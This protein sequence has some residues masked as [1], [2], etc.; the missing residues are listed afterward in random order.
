MSFELSLLSKYRTPLMGIAMLCV[1]FFHLPINDSEIPFILR[2]I[3]RI[4]FG[5]VDFFFFLSGL[6]IYFSMEKR[7]LKD[8]YQKRL[9]RILPYYIPVVA[10]FSLFFEYHN[11]LISIKDALLKIF[12]LDFWIQGNGL[13]W[14]IPVAI[15]FYI[16]TPFIMKCLCLNN[17]KYSVLAISVLLSVDLV[18]NYLFHYS[19][20]MYILVR[21]SDYILGIQIGYFITK[22]KRINIAWLV[23]SF[24]IGGLT[25][26]LNYLYSYQGGFIA[27][28]FR[29]IPFFFL[30]L[31]MCIFVSY[32]FSFAKE[33]K[34][35]LLTFIGTYTLCI[36]AFHERINE[37]LLFY[38]IPHPAL[39]GV[40]LA[41]ILAVLWQNFVSNILRKM[42][43]LF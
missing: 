6:G 14:Y 31:P 37:I 4:G 26:V 22:D 29:V 36:Y 43:L 8:F 28:A 25:L 35:P 20:F 27:V 41:F 12:L 21:L 15:L 19:P 33:Y 13:G 24:F 5:G 38:N 40:G 1:M 34:F 17:L 10:I 39:L 11:N 16:I 32:I 30:S 7:S 23:I 9:L 2:F 18:I 3:R 42:K